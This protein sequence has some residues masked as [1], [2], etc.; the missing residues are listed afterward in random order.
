MEDEILSFLRNPPV[1]MK[2]EQAEALCKVLR[3]DQDC[4]SVEDVAEQ[5][6][7]DWEDVLKKVKLQTAAKKRLFNA[8]KNISKKSSIPIPE[9]YLNNEKT[10]NILK[11]SKSKEVVLVS[12]IIKTTN[13]AYVTLKNNIRVTIHLSDEKW[14]HLE[15]EE[16]DE[17]E[18]CY[19]ITEPNTVV[20]IYDIQFPETYANNVSVS[21]KESIT[22]IIPY[23]M[24]SRGQ[25]Q[26]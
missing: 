9:K 12:R 1:E 3:D 26:K 17:I 6:E 14:K 22:Q 15:I 2:Q 4:K 21:S 18:C 23:S 10:S 16:G 20:T 25:E 13:R 24:H 19:S 8:I 11:K 5:T 7:T